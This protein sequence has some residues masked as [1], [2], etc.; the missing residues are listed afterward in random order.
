MRTPTSFFLTGV[1]RLGWL[2]F[3]ICLFVV[4]QAS[5]LPFREALYPLITS[6]MPAPQA[7]T[8][9]AGSNGPLCAG[10]TL[11]LTATVTDGTP[12]FTFAWSGP[13]GFAS[14][15]QNPSR[16]NTT[17]AHTG[18]YTV[19]VTDDTGMSAT[20]TVAVQINQPATADAGP[21]KVLCTGTPHQLNG[22]IG[23]SATS[24]TWTASVMGGSFV[25]NPQVLNAQYNPPANYQ[26]AI[27]LTLTTNDPPG[28][29]PAVSDQMLLTYG[30]PGA[31]VCN[32][33]VFI[34]MPQTCSVVVT[35]DMALEQDVLDDLYT[36]TLFTPQGQNIGNTITSQYVGI[37]LTIRVQDNCSGN[38]CI[39]IAIAF[40]NLPPQFLSCQN[41]TVP[42]VVNKY[43]PAYLRDTLGISAAFPTVVD[44]CTTPTL[45]FN[46]TW[47]DVPCGGVFNGINNLSGYIV[48]A[49]TATDQ[50]GNK[51]TCTQYVYF[52]R[53]GV[54]DL[55]L[56]ANVTV[57]CDM[58]MTNPAVTGAPSY[59]FNGVTFYINGT[60][61]FCEINTTAT[62]QVAPGCDG[63]YAILRTW[64]IFNLCN[65]SQP[66]VHLQAINV[67]DPQGPVI[68]C[69]GNLSVSTNPLACCATVDLPDVIME[70]ACGRVRDA[71]ATIF[72]RNPITGDTIATETVP[73]I[74]T[75]FPGNDPNK[76]DTLAVFGFTPCLPIGQ[77][78]V[79]YFAEDACGVS[80]S[81]TFTLTVTDLV[82][83]TVAC[84]EITQVTLGIDGMALINASTFD[85]GSYDNCGP[86]YFKA[87]RL[88]SNSCQTN[89]Q[90]LDQVKF[91]CE[92]VGD[93]IKV[94]LRVY[95][96]PLPAGPVSLSFQEPRSNECEVQVYVDDKLKPVCLAPA[97]TTV[98]CENF[99]PTL[100]SYGMATG[101]DN[102][103]VDTVFS[104]TTNWSQFDTM[105]SKG[106]ITRTFQVRD[107]HGLTSTCTQRVVVAYKQH[108]YVKFPDDVI[109]TSCNG[110]GDYGA[111]KFFGED[112]ELL[113]VSYTDQLFTV[114]PDACYKIERTWTV[115]N[116][117]TYNPNLGCTVVPNPNPHAQSNHPSNL[118]GPVVSPV[119]TL[120][121]WAPTVA[122]LTPDDAQAVNFS[123]YWSA[124]VNCYQY[125]QLIKIT[126]TQ[127]PIMQCPTSLVDVCDLTENNT[128]LWNQSYWYDPKTF[129]H[130][131]CEGPADLCIS[132]TDDCSKSNVTFRYQLFL[133]LDGNGS[134]ETVINSLTAEPNVV[135]F[136]NAGNPNF[137]GGI[138][139]AFDKRSVPFD[140][141][142]RFALETN[143]NGNDKV[144]C[145]RW[146]T[147]AQPNTYVVPEIP[148]GTHKIKWFVSDG[149]GN[150]QVCEYTF[151]I[152]DCKAPSTKC[153]NGLS[154]N[155]GS[156]KQ[157]TVNASL[158]VLDVEENC[159]PKNLIVHGIRKKGQGTGFP[160]L[161]NGSPQTSV[162]FDCTE[163]GYQLV[164]VWSRDLQGNADFCETFFH[165]QNN[166][167]NCSISHASVAGAVLTPQGHGLE[168][169]NVQIACQAINGA[170]PVT[171]HDMT[172]LNGYYQFNN[173]IPI[174]I[175]YTIT[176]VKDNDPLNGVSTFDLVLINRHILGYEP[177]TSPYKMIAAD[178]NN[179]GSITTF[180]LVELRK[181]IL[182]IYSDFPDNT[183]WRFVDKSYKFPM[184]SNPWTEIFPE[185]KSV[186]NFQT[187]NLDDD[188]VAIKIG[189]VNT[190]S[191][192]NSAMY[193]EER[194][195]GT[196]LFDVEDRFV[197]PGEHFTATFTAAT[198]VQAFQFTLN[199]TGLDIEDL[200]PGSGMGEDNFAVF[201]GQ[202]A[203][204]SSVQVPNSA[205]RAT[206]QV[207]FRATTAGQLSKMLNLSSRITRSEA[208]PDTDGAEKHDI[209][210][211]FNNGDEQTVTGIGFELY[212]NVPNPWV[213]KTQIGFYLPQAA[214]ATLTIFDDL[215]RAVFTETA[216]YNR[217]YNAIFIEHAL[218]DKPGILYYTLETP[219]GKATRKMVQAK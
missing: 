97:N 94:I 73:G 92:D 16:P 100:W 107:C 51:S 79:M 80:N 218:L 30:T 118:T 96:V 192:A 75:N 54:N 1:R 105:C 23:G 204:T 128:N 15:A 188:F 138:A 175:N 14:T 147:V 87:R 162:S 35:P 2:A 50:Y 6:I 217:G 63:R 187:N 11:N 65:A 89:S 83:P 219:Y 137:S 163:L 12:L 182:G 145:V 101:A 53:I 56:P 197:K 144:A 49:W 114:V 208:Y 19:T 166:D 4:V 45:T 168:E 201:P 98:D 170:P 136:N 55:T 195:T 31:L 191:I 8:V 132:A 60:N 181:L 117:C 109:I 173:S 151:V 58:P 210:L 43:T 150:E 81:C 85:D 174:A 68:A 167:N 106:T 5:S 184:P 205:D 190:T 153:V 115:I 121:P 22:S 212:Q 61:S 112:C 135:Y 28:P 7:V 194:S 40:D 129:S 116:W 159:T 202:H 9:T 104:T 103:C 52:Q 160:L 139:R 66:L 207:R 143:I 86:V 183:S 134:M 36:V 119:G 180:D 74:L 90:F 71:N 122:K 161:G 148:H 88:E 196:L 142:Y 131:L 176:P 91:C 214:D 110:S 185:S 37:P 76:N 18:T 38:F 64:Q 164:E 59:T 57:N 95:D 39:T 77:H 27:T 42:C 179:N 171:K 48:R 189:D 99:D 3:P 169:A 213:N 203:L 84:D 69:P 149:C 46:D 108:Y 113:G 177:F 67:V 141:K 186:W 154:G 178:V 152:K 41:I 25:P 193:T 216:D 156:D 70:D 172:D 155:I 32:D 34:A 158:F 24:A 10:A 47:V 157:I 13:A 125:K 126:D 130:D 198:R 120:F 209:A 127:K 146:N 93:T 133:D 29:C 123:T 140:Q 199:Y 124:N 102:C 200:V 20:A 21:D 72:I 44:N 62:D 165:V 82:P 33:T 78:I 206:F 17:L 211:R 215:G 26:G 111:P